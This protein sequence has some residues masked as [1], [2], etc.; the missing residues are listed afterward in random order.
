MSQSYVMGNP[1]AAVAL[2]PNP[3]RPLGSSCTLSFAQWDH[4]DA[5]LQN[6]VGTEVGRRLRRGMRWLYATRLR[7]AEITS[8]KCEDL[9]QVEYKSADGSQATDWLL[10]V[11]GKG[12]RSRQVPVPA[13]LV[14]ELGDQLARHGFERQVRAVSNQGI[15]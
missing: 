10:S 4:L 14:A 15:Q 12:G 1:F 5:L 9:E 2:P 6:H 7:L 3:R 8:V 11:N 13:E